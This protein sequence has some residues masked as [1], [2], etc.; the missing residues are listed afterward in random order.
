MFTLIKNIF[1]TLKRDNFNCNTRFI[2]LNDI[3][4]E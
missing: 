1:M 4:L 3:I 2:F